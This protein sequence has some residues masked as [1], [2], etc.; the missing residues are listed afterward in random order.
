[1]LRCL[2]PASGGRTVEYYEPPAAGEEQERDDLICDILTKMIRR[3]PTGWV[4]PSHTK[5]EWRLL[6]QYVVPGGLEKFISEHEQFQVVR[7]TPTTWEFG[8]AGRD[9]V[10]SDG[11]SQRQPVSDGACE[12]TDLPAEDMLA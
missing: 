7:L 3:S 4:S 8:F 11:A 10:V 9:Q 6:R 12:R 2:T 1:M 5:G